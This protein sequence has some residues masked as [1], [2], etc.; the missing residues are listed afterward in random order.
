MS[1]NATVTNVCL[2]A[3]AILWDAYSACTAGGAAAFRIGR[4][5][6]PLIRGGQ[7]G[8]VRVSEQEARFAFLE[9]VCHAGLLYTVEA[10]TQ[11]TYQFTGNTD[12]SAQTDLAVHS[13]D[14]AD[15]YCNV[16]FKAKGLSESAQN[17]FHIYKDFEKL[18]REPYSGVWYHLLESVNNSTINELITVMN[19]E[20][21]AV[22]AKF[23]EHIHSPWLSVHIC[24]LRH[25]FSLHIEAPTN[26]GVSLPHVDMK[27]TR[28]AISTVS[29]LNGW[30][31]SRRP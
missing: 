26:G 17:S 1:A 9:S 12:Q 30:A 4:L 24:V 21:A 29:G 14:G 10:P 3:D 6:F 5:L 31:L 13:S 20:I 23:P 18:L 22:Y 25:G 11:E 7:P 15:K 28:D 16:E 19:R 27:V 2:R 8:D